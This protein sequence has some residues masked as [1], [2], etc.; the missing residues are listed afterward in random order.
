MVNQISV[1]VQF[2]LHLVGSC[3]WSNSNLNIFYSNY[4]ITNVPVGFIYFILNFSKISSRANIEVLSTMAYCFINNHFGL[5]CHQFRS[6]NGMLSSQSNNDILLI[7]CHSSSHTL[8]CLIPIL[9]TSSVRFCSHYLFLG[10]YIIILI[11]KPHRW[12]MSIV[13]LCCL[14]HARL[15]KFEKICGF[16]LM[17]FRNFITFHF[18]KN[19]IFSG[20]CLSGVCHGTPW[21]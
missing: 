14:K 10:V 17:K 18:E 12:S 13:I 20:F 6:M 7:V 15:L 16:F 21:T 11:N 9:W 2:I 19:F 4:T 5:N 1:N 3:K 8:Y